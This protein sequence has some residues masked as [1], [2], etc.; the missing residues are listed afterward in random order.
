[1]TSSASKLE[2]VVVQKHTN[3]KIKIK[4]N[5]PTIDCFYSL[6]LLLKLSQGI[7]SLSLTQD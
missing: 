1:M 4:I 6:Q 3:Q 2:F 7:A 5:G